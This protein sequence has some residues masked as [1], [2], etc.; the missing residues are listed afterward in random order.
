MSKNATATQER[1]DKRTLRARWEGFE[2]SIHQEGRVTVRNV[3]KA[4]PTEY[5]VTVEGGRASSC[6][7]PDWKHREPEGGCKHMR[8]VE[9]QSGVMLAA[10]VGNEV[11]REDARPADCACLA[12][13]EGIPCWP[14]FSAG[15]ETPNPNVEEA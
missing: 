7:C 9:V 6:S 4:E 13:F 1:T 11:S 8:A 5:T 14:C 10:S 15:F 2:F 12:S 3:S